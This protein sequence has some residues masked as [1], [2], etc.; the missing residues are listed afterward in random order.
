[1]TEIDTGS[2]RRASTG[3]VGLDQL[4]NGGLTP[5]RMYLVEGNP[6]AGK[7]TLAMQFLLEGQRQGEVCLYVTLSETAA[8]L[9]A[10]AASHG[11]SLEGIELFQLEP[12]EG[13]TS[14]DQYTL[15]HPAEVE[16]GE[17]VKA[18]LE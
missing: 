6:G 1:M 17:T 18:V 8:E 11:W 2:E 14:D 16:L 4:L 10:V 7:T 5:H 15:Y 9:N 3:V 12:A 13:L